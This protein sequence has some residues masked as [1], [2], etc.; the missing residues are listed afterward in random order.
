VKRLPLVPL[1][2]LAALAAD[3]LAKSLVAANLEL[4]ASFSPIPALSRFFSIT[5]VTN[6]GAAFGLLREAGLFFVFVAVAVSAIILLYVRKL[7]ADQQL[8]R[9][10][11]GLQLGGALGNMVDRLRLGYV[12]DFIDVKFWPIF[13]IADSAI[14][15]GVV[16]LTLA[17]WR[18]ERSAARSPKPNPSAGSEQLPG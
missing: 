18:Q 11:L 10:A 9:A 15:I 1:L 14:V 8:V 17:F 12:V 7:P 2:A 6:T 4:G 5:Y 3:Q 16:L 13:N